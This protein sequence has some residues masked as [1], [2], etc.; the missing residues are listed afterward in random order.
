M[1]GRNRRKWTCWL[2]ACIPHGVDDLI[3]SF[4]SPERGKPQP[5]NPKRNRRKKHNRRR[6]LDPWEDPDWEPEE[7]WE[8]IEEIAW[9]Q[10]FHVETIL[11]AMRYHRCDLWGA[12]CQLNTPIIPDELTDW[13]YS[14]H[15]EHRVGGPSDPWKTWWW[16]STI[17]RCCKFIDLT[18]EHK[19]STT[20][21]EKVWIYTSYSS[22]GRVE[23]WFNRYG[24]LEWRPAALKRRSR[25]KRAGFHKRFPSAGSSVGNHNV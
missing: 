3:W 10:G 19:N 9:K 14:Y 5:Q 25:P 20:P 4:A 7:S 11:K 21:A 6:R 8:F 12:I 1:G 15:A 22:T 18:D 23:A 2:P 13:E 16:H 17:G 24:T